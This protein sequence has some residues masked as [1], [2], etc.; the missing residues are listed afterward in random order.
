MP[1]LIETLSMT[2]ANEKSFFSAISFLIFLFAADVSWKLEKNVQQMAL[3]SGSSESGQRYASDIAI[4]FC[5]LQ[6]HFINAE[7]SP[8]LVSRRNFFISS[9]ARSLVRWNEESFDF[10]VRFV[11]SFCTSFSATQLEGRSFSLSEVENCSPSLF[12]SMKFL[13][14]EGI[15]KEDYWQNMSKWAFD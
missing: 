11:S 2:W 14:S 4:G 13:L 3:D 15:R 6:I 5:S 10:K 12:S 1:S 8:D 9:L 7:C